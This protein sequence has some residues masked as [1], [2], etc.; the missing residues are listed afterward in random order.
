M[1]GAHRL[2]LYPLGYLNSWL[3]TRMLFFLYSAR[4]ISLE[5]DKGAP[6]NRHIPYL[7]FCRDF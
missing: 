2:C 6:L 5:I 1:V 7:F 4:I 3:I